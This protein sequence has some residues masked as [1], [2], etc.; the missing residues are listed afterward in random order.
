MMRLFDTHAHMIDPRFDEDREELFARMRAEGLIGHIEVIAAPDDID[1]AVRLA[2]EHEGVFLAA[3]IHPE[4]A[5]QYDEALETRVAEAARSTKAVA[6]GEIGLDYCCGID[7]RARQKDV[8]ERQ[9]RLAEQMELPVIIHSRDAMRDTLEMLQRFPKVHGVMHCFS[10][11]VET[12]QEAVRMGWYIGI[13]G[14]VTFKN[15]KKTVAVAKEAPL[16]RIL[17]ETDSPYLAPDPYRGKRNMPLY[18]GLVAER[19]GDIRGI[20]ADEVARASLENAKRL[21]GQKLGGL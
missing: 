2:E 5:D 11:S 4:D 1:A 16:D 9:M 14:T 10:G 17:L 6:I 18:T 13:G 8:F 7:D 15:N 19:I 12:A 3:G 20:S 21:F